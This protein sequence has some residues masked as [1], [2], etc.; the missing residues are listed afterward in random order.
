M[1]VD[2]LISEAYSGKDLQNFR[3]LLQE[4]LSNGILS[5]NEALSLINFELSKKV[6]YYELPTTKMEITKCP[7]CGYKLIMAKVD[8]VLINSC[9]KCRWSSLV[10]NK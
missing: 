8:G 6:T 2:M 4:L 3:T 7:H 10:E 1:G 5:V 9:K